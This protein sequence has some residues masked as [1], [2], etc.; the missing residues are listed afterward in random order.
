MKKLLISAAVGGIVLFIWGWLAWLLP[1]H[2]SSILT[3]NN[4][5]SVITP[6][7]VNM[8]QRGVY[9]F[10]AMPTTADQAAKDEWT[11]KYQ[12]GPTGMIIYNPEGSNPSN[13][14]QM[15][16]GLIISM[17][18]AFFV[19]WF[20]SRSTAAASSYIARV[21]YCG[22]LGIFVS[23]S[24]HMVNWNWME[25]PPD[26]TVGWIIDTVIGWLVA[27]VAISAFIKIRKPS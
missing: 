19:A 23:V 11:Q 9:V 21:A 6:M 1:I 24:V 14:G 27:G 4:E 7:Q 2:T 10:P 13:A 16:I 22:M 18:S 25:Y 15:I 8:E 5:D 26:Y 12:E 17:I 3:I 20:L